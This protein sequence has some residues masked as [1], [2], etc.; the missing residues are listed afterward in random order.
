MS[1]IS[2]RFP[3][4]QALDN[5]S[6]SISQGQIHGLV[7]KNGAGKS[8]LMNVLMGIISPDAGRIE[9]EGRHA[10]HLTPSRSRALGM[11][12]VP[13]EV[14]LFWPLSVTENL[15]GNTLPKSRLGF[16][17]WR[18]AHRQASE[19]LKGFALSLDPRT[20]V[21]RLTIGEQQILSVA[22]ALYHGARLIVLDEPTAPLTRPEVEK[23]FALMR[24]LR[25]DGVAF[26]YISHYLTEV[27]EICDMVSILYDG[28]SL[29]T[30]SVASLTEAELVNLI[31]GQ[32]I[33]TISRTLRSK[34]DILFS[35]R[36]LSRSGAFHDVDLD[37]H[38][39]EIVG[40]TGLAGSG[41]SELAKAIF[42]LERIDS[43]DMFLEGRSL[44]AISPEHSLKTGIAYLPE[45][46]RLYG[47]V[48]I[49]SVVQNISLAVLDRMRN[50]LGFLQKKVEVSLAMDYVG[51]LEIK[52][53]S[54]E[55]QVLYLSGGNQQKVVVGKLLATHPKMLLLGDPTRGIDVE[56]KAEVYRIVNEL[57]RQGIGIVIVSDEISELLNICDRILVM[58]KGSI[59]N[60]FARAEINARDILMAS[61]GIQLNV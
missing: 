17:K 18:K 38:K 9:V 1:G 45:E 51:S 7:G 20:S 28:K 48:P 26:I 47:L 35:V 46:R 32:K 25:A 52:T 24:K 33:Q 42:G 58:F 15:L 54:L 5:V 12:I 44:R 2:K 21:E 11:E 53:S 57:S 23:L 40:L 49:M 29:G 34:G 50:K 10:D 39:G 60:S 43:G 8:T 37:L 3:G 16:I 31:V 55:K 61:E 19:L 56:A 41:K 30:F 27:F 36:G 6:I 59:S 22:K 14:R 4:V 13:Q